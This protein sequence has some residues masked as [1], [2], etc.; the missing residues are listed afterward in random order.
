VQDVLGLNSIQFQ[1][2]DLGGAD[3]GP[4]GLLIPLATGGFLIEVDP[5]P[6]E[7]W[8][9]APLE[10]R[11]EITRHRTRF[12]VMH[13]FAHTLFYRCDTR[14][15]ERLIKGSV[16]QEEFCDALASALLV[17]PEAAAALPLRP[18]SAISL[19]RKY[20]VSVEVATRALVQA[21]EKAAGW[22]VILPG[23][24]SE[25]WVQWG[26]DTTRNAVG[27]WKLLTRLAESVK[28]EPSSSGRLLWRNG[29]TTVARGLYLAER[30][31]LVVTARAA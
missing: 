11:E 30:R 14:P 27:P 20:D 13:E 1:S 22:L 12:T 4:Q 10:L 26:A 24:R 29:H 6:P 16:A 21:H 2:S 5:S 15:P 17:P 28:E 19:H 7:G 23:D 18:E 25:P 31:Q 3:G 9:S 8:S